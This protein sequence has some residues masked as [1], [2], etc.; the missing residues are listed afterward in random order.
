MKTNKTY[1]ETVKAYERIIKQKNKEIEDL[2]GQISELE[3]LYDGYK[4]AYETEKYEKKQLWNDLVEEIHKR[5]A[6]EIEKEERESKTTKDVIM[7]WLKNCEQVIV[8]R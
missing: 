4:N 1:L 6:L 7:D 8:R 3:K 2:K 5:V